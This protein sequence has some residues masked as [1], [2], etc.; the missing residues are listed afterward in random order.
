MPFNNSQ[1]IVVSVGLQNFNYDQYYIDNYKEKN[2]IFLIHKE[3]TFYKNFGLGFSENFPT[4]IKYNLSN[5]TYKKL[6]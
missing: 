4:L 3:N 5:D 1:L 6:Y 2:I